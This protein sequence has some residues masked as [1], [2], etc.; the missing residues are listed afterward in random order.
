MRLSGLRAARPFRLFLAAL[1]ALALPFLA[2]AARAQP[3]DPEMMARLAVHAEA[4]ETMRT[5]ASYAL[6]GELDA[7]DG[8]GKVDS[9]KKMTAR[10]EADGEKTRLVVVKCTENGKDVTEDARKD[11]RTGNEKSKEERAKRYVELPLRASI[12]P[13]YVF[14]Q[15]AVNPADPTL[16]E[17]SFVPKEPSEHTSEGTAWID[18]KTGTLVSAGFKLSKPGFFVDYIHFTIEMG[19]KTSLGPAISRV[20]VDGKGG[21][22]FFRKHFRGEA[23]L[24]DYRILP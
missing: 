1:F 22:L 24:F 15:I 4:V 3:P 13:R 23:K 8:D 2:H 18:T 19:E 7:I 9:V 14:D 17:I 5:H 6:E 11:A 21:I 10:I 20:T 16:V 12:Q